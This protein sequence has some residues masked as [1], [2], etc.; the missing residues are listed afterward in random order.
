MKIME[1]KEIHETIKNEIIKDIFNHNEQMVAISK[2]IAS[3]FK[4]KRENKLQKGFVR[5]YGVERATEQN[6]IIK[7]TDLKK[8]AL[9]IYKK[10]NGESG[11]YNFTKFLWVEYPNGN[12]IRLDE[13]VPYP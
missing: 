11:Y 6:E 5:L 3:E 7:E 9:D 12:D 8:R 13:I 4:P 1:A 2:W 10:H